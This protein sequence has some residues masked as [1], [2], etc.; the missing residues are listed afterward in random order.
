MNLTDLLS[1]AKWLD[2][3]MDFY[4]RSGMNAY[5]F[6][7]MGDRIAGHKK[8]ANQ[9][10]PVIKGNPSKASNICGLSHQAMAAMAKK[11]RKIVV[12]ECEAGLLKVCVPVVVNGEFVGIVGGCGLL[13]E[14]GEVDV[15]MVS[16]VTGMDPALVERFA[17]DIRHLSREEIEEHIRYL[18][19]RVREF[20][21]RKAEARKPV[22]LKSFRN[23]IEEVQR[24]GRC[25]Q[26]GGCVT[27]CTAINYGA[28]ELGESGRPR[29]KDPDKCIECGV[30]Y[31]ICPA[32]GALDAEVKHKIGWE[33]PMGRV[34]EVTM[35]RAKDPDIRAR[36]TDGGAVTAILAHLHEQGSIDGAVVTRQTGP[37]QR[38][39][40][41]ASTKEEILDSAG[42]HFDRAHAGAMTLYQEAETTYSPSV[43]ALKP[44]VQKGLQRVAVVGAPCQVQSI[45]KMDTLG[46]VPS[47][48]IHCTLGLFCSGNFLFDAKRRQ[49]IERIGDFRWDEV[50]KINIKE[51]FIVRLQD[52][53]KRRLPLEEV[54]FAK[55]QA[56]RYCDDYSA[57]YADISFGGVGAPD[58]W[59]L[60]VARTPLGVHILNDAREAVLEELAPEQGDRDAARETVE[61][62][63]HKKRENAE[64]ALSEL[65][66]AATG[67]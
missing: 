22:E 50:E 20:S 54:D 19:D 57:E 31:M 46:V 33:A 34:A 7:T 47:D 1:P 16:A 27:F 44:V 39:P 58:G 35:A 2:F 51:D 5:A 29:Y 9:L 23:L 21:A 56:C 67:T 60:V 4:E 42:S 32:V 45:R 62:C 52:G 43:Q 64:S 38:S 10:C 53:E 25:H 41:L 24:P 66:Q 15:D 18:E 26:C 8:W 3:D 65:E 59:T 48:S 17:G 30:C 63:S 12:G 28:L 61:A 36:A 13:A 6:D 40:W 37:F 11:Q 49:K 14:N 55:R